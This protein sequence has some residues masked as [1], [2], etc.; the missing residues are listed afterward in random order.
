MSTAIELLTARV[1]LL[2][3]VLNS[4]QIALTNL[5]SSEAVNQI[6]LLVQTDVQD[7]QTDILQLRRELDLVEAEVYR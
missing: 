5:A 2:E 4:V 7:L 1:T 6:T 3:E